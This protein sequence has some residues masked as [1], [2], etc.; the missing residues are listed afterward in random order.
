MFFCANAEPFTERI[1]NFIKNK[2]RNATINWFE[3]GLSAY[4]FDQRYFPNLTSKIKN[5]AIYLIERVYRLTTFVDNYYVF[6]PNLMEWHPKAKVCKIEGLNEAIVY[7]LGQIFNVSDCLDEYK[8]KY[9]FFEDGAQ[10]W[11]KESDIKL[12]NLIAE[13]VGKEN[14]IVRI[15]PRNPVN[16]FKKLGYKTNQDTSIPWE[17]LV[18][19]IEIKNKVLITMYSQ[20]VV[21]PEILL[22]LKPK[23]LL[24]A[25]LDPYYEQKN[26]DIFDFMNRAFFEK[27]KEHYIVPMNME[28]FNQTVADL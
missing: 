17:V 24:M 28:E 18:A 15:H 9:I 27:D 23:A 22:G 8:E 7:E 16:R 19:N 3:D 1:A 25:N 13:K 4:Y 5:K 26:H 20:C 21:T 6:N 10:D 11:K 12:V 2:N 14:I